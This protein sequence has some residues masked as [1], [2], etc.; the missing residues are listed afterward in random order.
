[1]AAA[2][3]ENEREPYF[4]CRVPE[5]MKRLAE[6]RASELGM[7]NSEYLRSLIEDDLEEAEWVDA[8]EGAE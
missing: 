8:V 5:K 6:M 7:N 1:M 2:D 3:S 4:G